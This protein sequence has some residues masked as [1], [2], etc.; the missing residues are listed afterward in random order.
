MR[1]TT[2]GCM[3]WYFAVL[4]NYAGFSGRAR[5]T[6]YWMFV[7]F[8]VI[9]TLVLDLIG[10]AVKLGTILGLVYGLAVLIPSLAVGVRR[11][12]DTGRTGWWLLIGIIPIIG[13]IILLVFMATPGNR[14]DNAYGPDPK[15]APQP[16]A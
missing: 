2:G 8:N 4:R 11:L 5:R 6:E 1:E 9:A 10:M 13:T 7:L 14:G 15:L 16:S 3:S 12:H